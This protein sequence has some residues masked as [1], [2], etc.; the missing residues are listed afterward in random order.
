MSQLPSRKGYIVRQHTF[1]AFSKQ[2][3]NFDRTVIITISCWSQSGAYRRNHSFHTTSRFSENDTSIKPLT[4]QKDLFAKKCL[5]CKA[6]FKKQGVFKLLCR[7]FSQ[8]YLLPQTFKPH[9]KN[10]QF[11]LFYRKVPNRP[12]M[13]ASMSASRS[14]AS[15]SNK[16]GC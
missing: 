6:Q 15:N 16:R 12:E 11:V 7:S 5:C 14:E 13:A 10:T 3:S 4:E 2:R 1:E 9:K 8:S